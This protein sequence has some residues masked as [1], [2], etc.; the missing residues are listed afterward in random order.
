MGPSD[1]PEHTRRDVG[2]GRVWR[3]DAPAKLVLDRPR[4]TFYIGS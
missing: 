3:S 2:P 1:D 4:T